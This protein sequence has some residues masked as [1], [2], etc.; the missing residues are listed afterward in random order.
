MAHNI[1][2]QRAGDDRPLTQVKVRGF[3]LDA[4][5]GQVQLEITVLRISTGYLME[6]GPSALDVPE[7]FRKALQEWLDTGN[8]V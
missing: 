6:D 4:D 7:D 3:E 8:E 1:D 5:K 2:T